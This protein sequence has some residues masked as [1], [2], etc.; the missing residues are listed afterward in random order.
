M[1]IIDGLNGVITGAEKDDTPWRDLYEWA[2]AP[3]KAMNIAVVT[4]ANHGKDRTLGPHGSSVLQ[5]KPD[6]IVR[7]DRTDGGAKLTTTHRRTS[8]YPLEQ[9]FTVSGVDSTDPIHSGEA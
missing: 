9:T 7:I 6:A 5:D 1:V 8:A 3:L 2:I 4:A